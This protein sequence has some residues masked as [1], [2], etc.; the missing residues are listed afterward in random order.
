MK[1]PTDSHWA[2]A[3]Y[4]QQAQARKNRAWK[5]VFRPSAIASYLAI[6]GRIIV[7]PLALLLLFTLTGY[8]SD[9]TVFIEAD[10]SIF[11]FTERDSSMAGGCTGCLGPCKIVMLKY[12]LLEGVAITSAPPFF[13]FTSLPPTESLYD[14]SSLSDE[15]LAFSE[16][17]DAN[18]TLCQSSKNEWGT[19]PIVVTG[20]AQEL[21]NIVHMANLNLSP[22]MVRE[23][24]LA[25]ERA[26]EC[27]TGWTM[28]SVVRLFQY[29]TAEG[30]S[31]FGQVPAV[32]TH[33]FP[34]YTECRPVVEIDDSLVGSKLALDTNGQD[35]LKVVPDQL[36]LFP[37]S[38]TSSLPPI[39]RSV[40]AD[41]SKT[42]TGATSVVQSYLRAYYGGCRVRA[43]N[44]TGIYIEDT[45]AISKHW[46]G[47]GLM[48]HSPDDIPLCS[49]GDVCIHN[50][51]NSLW[52]WEHYV[53]ADRPDRVGMNLNTFRS[54]YADTVAISVLPG[55]VVGQIL[56]MGVVS[57]YQVMSHK[58]SVLLT[59]IWAYR[60]Q[61]GRMQVIYLAQISYHLLYNSDL[62]MLGLATG[63]LTGESIANLTCC[64]FAFSYSF[65]NLMKARSGDQQLDRHFRL[66][67]EAMQIVITTIV[68]CLLLSWQKAPFESILAQNAEILRKTSARGAKYCGLN[69]ACVLFT[70]NFPSVIAVLSVG[71]G[72][73][74]VVASLLMKRMAPKASR[75]VRGSY[76]TPKIAVADVNGKKQ[77]AYE[78][79]N[80]DLTSFERNCLGSPFHK[81]FSDCDEITYVT[82]NGKRCTTVEALLLTG[83]LYYG[84]HIYQASSVMLLLVARLVPAKILRTFNVLLLR[85]HVDPIEGT[86]S[87]ALSC[88]WYAASAEDHK[89]AAATP[90]A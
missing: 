87:H 86:L 23:L 48:V 21:L 18:G 64:V 67:W 53:A 50:Y 57:L 46:V 42:K 11:A 40:P 62:Y 76:V 8:L 27:V 32:D 1:G 59:Q 6:A 58:R 15:V 37:Y 9:A 10:R 28:M 85:W 22:Q 89:M 33:I 45:C 55:V 77:A 79:E 52:E 36:T 88:T 7:G 43:V 16:A 68:G 69:D 56:L 78:A 83:Y 90:V 17:L 75:S 24:E 84:Q 5:S 49:T 34:D 13:T 26:D 82:Y 60:C 47:Y 20:S 41:P 3:Y 19:S 72:F 66:I 30:S 70:V 73:V 39:P 38:F 31:E 74:A 29:P 14:F 35:P 25:I 81:L 51:F 54:R 2:E 65:V 4:H 71:F 61:N 80:D 44:T 63:T 12:K